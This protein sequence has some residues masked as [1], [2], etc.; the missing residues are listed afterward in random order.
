MVKISEL[1]V[2]HSLF[3]YSRF[4]NF[5]NAAQRGSTSLFSQ[6]QSPKFR[7]APQLAQ[8]PLHSSRQSLRAGT[9]SNTCSLTISSISMASPSNT[10]SDIASSGN[11][12]T[13]VD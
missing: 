9:K 8:I 4:A 12:A 13:L 6:W 7:S 2:H 5:F 1:A 11:S 3:D 10:E